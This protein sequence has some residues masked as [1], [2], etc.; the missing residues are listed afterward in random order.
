M[1]TCYRTMRVNG[2]VQERRVCEVC[3]EL[4]LLTRAH[5]LTHAHAHSTHAHAKA[6]THEHAH[7]QHWNT[8]CHKRKRFIVLKKCAHAPANGPRRKYTQSSAAVPAFGACVAPPSPPAQQ[9]PVILIN[10]H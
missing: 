5:S 6:C 3:C 4:G 8:Q 10:Q 2:A 9:Q 1:N 7:I